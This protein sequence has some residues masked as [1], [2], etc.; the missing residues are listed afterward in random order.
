MKKHIPNLIT[1][2]NL[3]S[4]M[5]AI[6]FIFQRDW[7]WAAGFVLLGIFFDFFDGL[8]ARTFKVSSEMGLQLDSLADMVTSGLAP[9]FAMFF[10][11]QDALGVNLSEGIYFDNNHLLPFFGFI[12]ALG[13]ALRLAKFNIDERQTSSFIGLPTPANSLLILSLPLI[14]YHQNFERLNHFILNP[15]T[16]IIISIFSAYILNAE[17][18]LFSLKFKN[19]SWKDNSEKYILIF[20]SIILIPLFKFVSVPIIIFIY[21]LLSLI[22]KRKIL[23]NS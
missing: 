10:L 17:M 21:L 13:S 22:Y 7:L 12:I 19:F 4:G 15:Y 2:L 16:L 5:I 11:L 1:M 23:T 6:F 3:S 18:P 9:A 8:A 14:V 20:L